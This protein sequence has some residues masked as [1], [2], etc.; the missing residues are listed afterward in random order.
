HC[1]RRGYVGLRGTT[2]VW[3]KACQ[4]ALHRSPPTSADIGLP[5]RASPCR[6][7]LSP[8]KIINLSRG[9]QPQR[10][11]LQHNLTVPPPQATVED[12]MPRT[13]NSPTAT[14]CSIL[15]LS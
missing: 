13:S 4:C 8:P 5:S 10:F 6:P 14:A 3:G 2:A 9:E 11:C 1:C 15:P 12:H 7:A